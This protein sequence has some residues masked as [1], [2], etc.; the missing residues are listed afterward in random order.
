MNAAELFN[1]AAIYLARPLDVVGIIYG[2]Y[3]FEA[4]RAIIAELLYSIGDR[5][6]PLSRVC[7]GLF[8]LF[9]IFIAKFNEKFSSH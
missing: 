5:S 4:R 8:H 7:M 6:R 2:V 1:W 3:G 9:T